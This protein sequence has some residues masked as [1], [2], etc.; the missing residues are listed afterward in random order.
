MLLNMKIKLTKK[1]YFLEPKKFK[2]FIRF[3][4]NSWWLI[5]Q[6]YR[7]INLLENSKLFSIKIR[8]LFI[9]H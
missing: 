7:K 8:P 4:V 5:A 9:L 1:N 3:S 2:K 6:V